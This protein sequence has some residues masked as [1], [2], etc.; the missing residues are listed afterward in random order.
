[1]GHALVGALLA[2]GACAETDTRRHMVAVSTDLPG[3]ACT[4]TRGGEPV[5]VVPTTPGTA[6]LSF[7]AKD[8]RLFCTMGGY[9]PA[10]AALP[11]EAIPE[12]LALYVLAGGI[13]GLAG[14][15]MSGDAHRYPAS[16]NVV[17]PP[18]RFTTADERDRYFAARAADTRG[19]F[20]ALLRVERSLCGSNEPS[21]QQ[22]IGEIERAREAELAQIEAAKVSTQT[23]A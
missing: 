2:L 6:A 14:G 5:A 22:R 1:M 16:I 18:I 15:A 13:G 10:T 9:A 11:A 3:A 8:A 21:C 20:D 23:G 17:L 4:V 7:S 19:H 12:R